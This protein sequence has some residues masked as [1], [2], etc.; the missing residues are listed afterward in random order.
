MHGKRKLKN[1]E[2]LLSLAQ[3]SRGMI[4]ASGARGP[5][6]K[7]RLSPLQNIFTIHPSFFA[8]NFCICKSKTLNWKY[9]THHAKIIRFAPIWQKP[10]YRLLTIGVFL[11]SHSISYALLF[12][13]GALIQ[14][15]K[16]TRVCHTYSE[17]IVHLS[18]LSLSQA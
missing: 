7:S 1:R 9:L 12:S 17:S 13:S 2:V 18:P 4:R 16:T 14:F 8:A 3:W 10:Y 5:G 15:L 6:F 11:S